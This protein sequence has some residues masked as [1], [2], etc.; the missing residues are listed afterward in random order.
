M[1][2]L[3]VIVFMFRVIFINIVFKNIIVKVMKI[4]CICWFKFGYS[5]TMH[6]LKNIKSVNYFTN[7][8]MIITSLAFK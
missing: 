6:S 2:I 1:H 8:W 4:V 3:I 7:P 5:M